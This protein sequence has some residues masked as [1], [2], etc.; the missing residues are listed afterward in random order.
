MIK[1]VMSRLGLSLLCCVGVPKV[2]LKGPIYRR[3]FRGE[4]KFSWFV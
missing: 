2:V 3:F 1:I 4:I